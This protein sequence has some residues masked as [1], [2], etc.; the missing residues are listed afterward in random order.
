[1]SS[2]GIDGSDYNQNYE[3]DNKESRRNENSPK[4]KKRRA[5]VLFLKAKMRKMKRIAV[6]KLVIEKRRQEA[7]MEIEEFINWTMQQI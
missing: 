5:R 2:N 7:E 6:D 3:C 1:M 4:K